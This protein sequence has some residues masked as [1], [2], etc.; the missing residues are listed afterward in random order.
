MKKNLRE[1]SITILLFAS[2]A[3]SIFYLS[4]L[5]KKQHDP[6]DGKNW[7]ALYFKN[8]KDYSMDFTI[9]NHS[10]NENFTLEIFVERNRIR[11]EE[12]YLKK[13]A[14]KDIQVT[15]SEMEGTGKKILIKVSGDGQMKE[16][17]KIL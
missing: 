11:N 14:K 10:R 6:D 9:E 7:W 5:E 1:N 8:P 3:V 16:I 15:H 4:F 13:G 17:Y 2:M 12:L